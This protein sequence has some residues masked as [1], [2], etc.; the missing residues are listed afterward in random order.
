MSPQRTTRQSQV[1]AHGPFSSRYWFLEGKDP[2]YDPV[3]F[4]GGAFQTKRSLVRFAEVFAESADVILV[5]L[6][7]TGKTDIPPPEIGGDFFAD[8]IR[9]LLDRLHVEKINLVGVSFGTAIAYTFAQRHPERT[10]N[11]VLIGTMSH[12]DRHIEHALETSF[13]ALEDGDLEAF[14]DRVSRVL[15]NHERTDDIPEF[16]RGE[17]LLRAALARMTDREVEQFRINGRRILLHRRLDT[18]RPISARALVFTGEYDSVTTPEHCL[19]VAKT[20]PG[21][22]WVLVRQADH[23]VVLERFDVCVA[24][25][26]AFL[27]GKD[28]EDGPDL[29]AVRRV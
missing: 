2:D 20:I 28:P 27:R 7:G 22:W 24:L 3:L 16:R 23:L 6:P 11:L 25:T 4:I 8:C 18:S 10:A 12:A 14:A 26:D 29:S 17:R 19:E 1:V 13:D 21:A 5:D 9:D 15:L